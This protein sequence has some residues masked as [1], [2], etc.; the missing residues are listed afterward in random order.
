MPRLH[1][2]SRDVGILLISQAAQLSSGSLFS[3]YKRHCSPGG[4][5]QKKKKKFE[6]FAFSC[7]VKIIR[8]SLDQDSRDKVIVSRIVSLLSERRE[9]QV[10]A[11][12]RFSCICE[13]AFILWLLEPQRSTSMSKFEECPT[14]TSSIFSCKENITFVTFFPGVTSFSHRPVVWNQIAG[15]LS[16]FSVFEHVHVNLFFGLHV[17]PMRWTGQVVFHRGESVAAPV[18]HSSVT[19]CGWLVTG[20]CCLSP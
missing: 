18:S 17:S 3:P 6:N 1:Y 15:F 12:A 2:G 10:Q 14:I 11:T 16:R 20:A 5:R 7:D 13:R 4:I 9:N 19:E 8:Y